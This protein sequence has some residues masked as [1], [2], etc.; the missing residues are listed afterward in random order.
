MCFSG[1]LY[2]NLHSFVC[3][4]RVSSTTNTKYNFLKLIVISNVVS[5]FDSR[6]GMKLIS[7]HDKSIHI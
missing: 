3:Q 2:T 5:T 6:V 7:Y 4:V 1:L